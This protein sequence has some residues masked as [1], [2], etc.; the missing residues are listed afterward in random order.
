MPK[1]EEE[2]L[3]RKTKEINKKTDVNHTA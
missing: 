1:I 3:K 2:R